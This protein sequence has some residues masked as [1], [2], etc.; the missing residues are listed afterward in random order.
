MGKCK[1]HIPISLRGILLTLT[2]AL[3]LNA[4]AQYDPYFS[5]YYDLQTQ[6][7]PAAA[8]K[9]AR[10]NLAGVYA[11]TMAGFSNAPQTAYVSGDMPMQLGKTIHGFGV[12]FMNDKAGLFTDMRFNGQYALRLKARKGWLSLGVQ[13]GLINEKFRG[14]EAVTPEDG[15]D[16]AIT[17]SDITGS[18]IDLGA[19]LYYRRANWYAGLAAQHI[20]SPT[21]TLGTTNERSIKPHFYANGGADWQLRNPAWK[22]ATSALVRYENTAWRGDITG[23]LIY[24]HDKLNLQGGFSYSPQNS[25]TVLAGGVFKGVMVGYSFEIYTNGISARNG[26]HELFLGYQM[27]IDLTKKGKNRHQTTRTL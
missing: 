21:I 26:S 17:K 4:S 11:M 12:Q 27:D 9:E 14:S 13:F 1:R 6:F 23:R 8:G 2:L 19:G 15:T 3:T 7:N 24:T 16:P 10:L 5:H 25:V 22:V 20:T 18:T